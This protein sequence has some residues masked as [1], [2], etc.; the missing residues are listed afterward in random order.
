MAVLD[1]GIDPNVQI[2]PGACFPGVDLSGEG[3]PDQ[4]SY[5]HAPS[6]PASSPGTAHLRMGCTRARLLGAGLV[7]VKVAG[8]SGQTDTGDADRR[9][10]WVIAHHV[11]EHIGVLN[12]SLGAIPD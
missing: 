11:S 8:A 9:R 7:S 6:S 12:L 1:T 4:D 3:N 10:A 5:G 2:S